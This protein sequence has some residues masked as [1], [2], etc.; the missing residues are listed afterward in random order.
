MTV[1]GFWLFLALCGVLLGG[2]Y[3]YTRV[4]IKHAQNK[5]K[6]ELRQREFIEKVERF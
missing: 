1:Y 6:R 4:V 5:E 3:L 2:S